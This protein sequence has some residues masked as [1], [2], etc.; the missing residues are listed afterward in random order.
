MWSPDTP[1]IRDYFPPHSHSILNPH[2]SPYYGGYL[3]ALCIIVLSLHKEK[4]SGGQHAAAVCVCLPA[5]L[6]VCQPAC[7][8]QLVNVIHCDLVCIGSVPTIGFFLDNFVNSPTIVRDNSL[9]VVRDY[10][11]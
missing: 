5:C 11:Q 4:F 9:T 7:F 2:S 10:S 8:A 1:I 6:C 3:L